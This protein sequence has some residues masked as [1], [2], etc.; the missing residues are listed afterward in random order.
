MEEEIAKLQVKM[1]DPD[2]YQQDAEA[3]GKFNQHLM[4]EEA[5]LAELYQR[6]ELLEDK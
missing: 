6:W 1:A 4:D 3:I 5:K 2:F